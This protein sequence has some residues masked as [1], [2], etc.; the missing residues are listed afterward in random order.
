[1][2]SNPTLSASLRFASYGSAGHQCLSTRAA[3]RMRGP[4]AVPARR[5]QC[6]P[7]APTQERASRADL[8]KVADVNVADSE[9]DH[10]RPLVPWHFHTILSGGDVNEYHADFSRVVVP[11]F[12]KHEQRDDNRARGLID[13]R[14][15][16][17]SHL[18]NDNVVIFRR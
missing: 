5:L 13:R 9:M 4:P 16:G 3:R 11:P 7:T 10:L 15:T 14:R 18:A 17:P 6:T 12:P 8:G 1:V 2:G